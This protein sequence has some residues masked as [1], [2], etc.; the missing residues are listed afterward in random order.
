MTRARALADRFWPGPLT[1]VLPRAPGFKVD[2]GGAATDSVAVRIPG[3]RNRARPPTTGWTAGSVERQPLRLEA[4]ALT[5]EEAKA[6]LGG[7][8]DT[9]L[10]GGPLFGRPSTIVSL[11]GEL[12][13]IREGEVAF[14]EIQSAMS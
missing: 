14:A 3:S 13:S 6:A 10:D 7:S 11:L 9:F 2:L 4:A 1:L 12:R 8:V 5:L